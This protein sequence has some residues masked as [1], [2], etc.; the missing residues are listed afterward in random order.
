[1]HKHDLGVHTEMITSSMGQLMK[2]GVITNAR[3]NYNTGKTI[4]CFAWGDQELY[5]YIANNPNVV[6]H[7]ASYTNRPE[8]IAMNDNMVSVNAIM[9]MDLTGQICSES[10]GPKQF[11]GAGGAFDF[12]FGATHSKGGKSII[13]TASTA[14]NGTISKISAV[15]PLGSVVT[16]PRNVTDYVVT[17]YGIARLTGKT[18]R[19]RVDALIAIAHPDFRAELRKDAE[20]YKLW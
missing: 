8:I 2:A 7:P 9:Q 14:K 5:D 20:K 4:G 1:M 16:I 18:V 6:L 12:A 15:L 3:K 19:Q 17:E 13:A 11:S 10:I